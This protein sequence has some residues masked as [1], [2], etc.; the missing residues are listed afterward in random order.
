MS[1]DFLH[2]HIIKHLC[3]TFITLQVVTV[4]MGRILLTIKHL[5]ALTKICQRPSLPGH[6]PFIIDSTVG[7]GQF[8]R[9]KNSCE[10]D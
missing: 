9:V 3:H 7:Y 10:M 2:N 6:V 1:E 4:H 8:C 5:S